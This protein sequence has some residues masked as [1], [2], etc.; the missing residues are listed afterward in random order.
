MG[1]IT[2]LGT[3]LPCWGDDKGRTIGDD[4]D[5][6][7]LAVAAGLSALSDVDAASVQRVVL[8]SRD[9]PL[10]EGG[11]S[12]A[13]LAGLGLSDHTP[14]SE[15]I[16]GAPVTLDSVA[17]A[18]PGTLV[19][20]S[21]VSADGAG[22]AAALVGVGARGATLTAVDR[23][24]RSLPVVTRD[25]RG[26]S[27]DYADPRLL[28]VRGVGESLER[29]DHD[30]PVVAV[31]G[32]AGR[33]AALVAKQAPALP[34]TGA[35][36][37]LFALAAMFDSG[38]SGRLAAIEQAT[39]TI[40]ELGAGGGAVTVTRDE[41]SAR[42]VPKGS[43]T[44]GSDLPVSLSAF[45]RAF[46]PKLRLEAARCTE[47]GTLSYPPRFRC[48]GCGAEQATKP[49]ALPRRAEIYTLATIRVPVPG[50]IS[51]YTVTLVELGDS[52]VRLLVRLTGS[53]AGSVSIGDRGKLVLRLVAVRSGV[54]D[55]GYGFLPDEQAS[56]TEAKDTAKEVAA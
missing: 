48:L 37:P 7:T 6:V 13:V 51:P 42:P 46:D 21:D 12:A 3:Y 40:A 14:V 54:P 50:L 25:A 55:Y 44:P 47:C 38:L 26:K 19:I 15:V 2:S 16:G 34:A 23:V 29:V 45:D 11:N 36:S 20:G 49:V 31:A 9:L 4:E 52:G 41:R 8:I 10:L 35:S 39:V 1:T 33:D 5:A 28:R 18:A 22:A 27:T 17:R 53:D 56:D 24:T 32:L 30:Q 43:F